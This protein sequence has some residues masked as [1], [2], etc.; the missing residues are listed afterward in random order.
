MYS[1][2]LVYFIFLEQTIS[3]RGLNNVIIQLFIMDGLFE[4]IDRD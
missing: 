2:F 4:I 1:V 3:E